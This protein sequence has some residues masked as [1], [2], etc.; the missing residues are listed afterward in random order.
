[1]KLGVR[2]LLDIVP[3]DTKIV[4]GSHGRND[5]AVGH[6]PV[7]IG[8]GPPNSGDSLPCESVRDLLLEL[9]FA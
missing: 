4:R 3:L 2:T 9:I 1:M 5:P 8:V 7:L 6:G